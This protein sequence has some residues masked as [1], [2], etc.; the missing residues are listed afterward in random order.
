MR[1]A[2]CKLAGAA[3]LLLLGRAGAA[4]NKKEEVLAVVEGGYYKK[5][6]LTNVSLEIATIGRLP[7]ECVKAPEP[8]KK[9]A[10]QLWKSHEQEMEDLE[11]MEDE[12]TQGAHPITVKVVHYLTNGT[13]F[14]EEEHVDVQW[15]AHAM[16][17]FEEMDQGKFMGTETFQYIHFAHNMCIG[18]TRRI[19]VMPKKGQK[20]DIHEFEMKVDVGTVNEVTMLRHG[21]DEL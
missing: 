3:L 11:D 8:E 2:C 19:T 17:D 12:E 14:E 16:H 13:S 21:H 5:F 10:E 9:P 18:E 1:G 20:L 15:H 6:N 7:A 4:A